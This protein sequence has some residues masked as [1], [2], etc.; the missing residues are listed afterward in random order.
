MHVR[1]TILYLNCIYNRIPENEPFVSKHVE[2]IEIKNRSIKLENMHFV[3]LY[4]IILLQ[5]T[6]RKT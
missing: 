4:C 6:V 1:H 2:G 3:C 5:G